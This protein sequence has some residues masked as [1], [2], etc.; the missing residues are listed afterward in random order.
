MDEYCRMYMY[1]QQCVMSNNMS[2]TSSPA[3]SEKLRIIRGSTDSRYEKYDKYETY[4]LTNEMLKFTRT[5]NSNRSSINGFR[6]L[7]N[8]STQDTAI[9]TESSNVCVAMSDKIVQTEKTK[10]CKIS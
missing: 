5:N 2:S 3:I 8:T 7:V 4:P 10:C 6:K 1:A 9:Q